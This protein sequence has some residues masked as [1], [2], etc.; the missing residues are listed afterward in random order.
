MRSYFEE[1]AVTVRNG[2]VHGLGE[3][4]RLADIPEPVGGAHWD[5]DEAASILKNFLLPVI[6]DLK[7]VPADQRV[8]N[9]IEKF[10]KMGFWEEV[11]E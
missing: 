6:K 4:N 11:N 10:G 3:V 2:R 5:Y 1:D 9:R 7:Q 8:K